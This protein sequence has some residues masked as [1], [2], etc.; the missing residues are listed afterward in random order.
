M[1]FVGA[2][3]RLIVSLWLIIG[4]TV[5][6]AG[7]GVAPG[8]GCTTGHD[9]S[10]GLGNWSA[11]VKVRLRSIIGYRAR[12][13]SRLRSHNQVLH[14]VRIFLGTQHHVIEI[15]SIQQCGKHI[16]RWTGSQISNDTFGRV[17]RQV[18]NRSR[19]LMN[20]SQNVA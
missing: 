14:I 8:I 13:S 4:G 15:G 20:S 5:I 11:P 18:N 3:L 1:W 2:F 9:R 16:A 17:W 10:I 12:V 6:G 19:L 7:I